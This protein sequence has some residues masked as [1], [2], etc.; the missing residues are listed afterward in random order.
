MKNWKPDCI[1]KDYGGHCQAIH[2]PL[3]TASA[4]TVYGLCLTPEGGSSDGV[5]SVHGPLPEGSTFVY[6]QTFFF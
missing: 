2:F 1:S 6:E 5:H 4:G 3:T